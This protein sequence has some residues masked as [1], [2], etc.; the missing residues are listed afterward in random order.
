MCI[1]TYYKS[2]RKK[3][4]IKSRTNNIILCFFNSI[5]VTHFIIPFGKFWPPNLGKATSAARAALPSPTTVQ[6][7]AGYFIV[8]VIYRTLIWT[9]GFLTCVRDH[10]YACVYTQGLG[11][12][13]RK[14]PSLIHSPIHEST[15]DQSESL[16]IR[17][18]LSYSHVGLGDSFSQQ[19]KTSKILLSIRSILYYT[20]FHTLK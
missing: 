20:L 6:M 5:F 12:P 3:N 8:S 16:Y 11:I 4:P 13:S 1:N 18:K 9:T 14:Y 10:S 17:H 15:K 2:W 19:P 7:H